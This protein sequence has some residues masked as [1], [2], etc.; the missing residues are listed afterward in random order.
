[1]RSPRRILFAAEGCRFIAL[2]GSDEDEERGTVPFDAFIVKPADPVARYGATGG[3][4]AV[5][6]AV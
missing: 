4:V 2:T 5:L 6:A 3:V 1:L